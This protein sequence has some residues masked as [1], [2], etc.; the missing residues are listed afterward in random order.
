[1]TTTNPLFPGDPGPPDGW[2]PEESD[3]KAKHALDAVMRDIRGERHLF[4][5]IV[6]VCQRGKMADEENCSAWNAVRV[7]NGEPDRNDR[8]R[9][10]S[11]L[12]VDW[13]ESLVEY[14]P[15]AQLLELRALLAQAL[16]ALD[17]ANR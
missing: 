16:E 14:V 9:S 8:N 17:P 12:G 13:E 3:R 15:K 4:P 10:G 6:V 11:T 7:F 1:M 5:E 2:E